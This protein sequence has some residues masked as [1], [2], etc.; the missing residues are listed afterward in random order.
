MANA[1]GPAAHYSL[2]TMLVSCM[3]LMPAPCTLAAPTTDPI[4]Y[5]LKHPSGRCTMIHSLQHGMRCCSSIRIAAAD[6]SCCSLLP[7]VNPCGGGG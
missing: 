1:A 3:V 5:L 2:D 4:H 6:P 7:A